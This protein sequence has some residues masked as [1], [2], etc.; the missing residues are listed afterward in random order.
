MIDFGFSRI[1]TK[2]HQILYDYCGTPN[3]IAPE[4][5]QREGY[6]GKPADIWSVGILV[7]KLVTGTFP[8]KKI[9]DKEGHPKNHKCELKVPSEVSQELGQLL[10]LML[11]YDYWRRPT[12]EEILASDWLN[13]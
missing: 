6:Y 3:Y 12:A 11:S 5:T 4:V 1:L 13:S 9:Q 10:N 2:D 8:S 7:Y